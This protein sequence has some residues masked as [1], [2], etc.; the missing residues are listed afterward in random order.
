MA[1][2]V[3]RIFA[4]GAKDPT[5]EEKR[6]DDALW[7]PFFL[8]KEILTAF[9]CVYVAFVATVAILFGYSETHDGL[10]T[11]NPSYFLL[12]Q[13]GPTAVLTLVAAFWGQVE[14]RT[15]QLAPWALMA[16][17]PQPAER[18]ILLDFI[19]PLALVSLA[20][21][22]RTPGTYAVAVAIVG[23]LL[24]KLATVLSTGLF[25]LQP[26]IVHRAAHDLMAFN[27]F[28]DVNY[29]S[30]SI[31]R[32][33]FA[34]VSSINM[35]GLVNVFHSDLEC[36]TLSIERV[37]SWHYDRTMSSGEGT[38]LIFNLSSTTC[39]T[40]DARMPVVD[41]YFE[42]T[43]VY[44]GPTPNLDPLSASCQDEG[45]YLYVFGTA[46]VTETMEAVP[47]NLF[48]T[49]NLLC[50]PSYGVQQAQVTIHTNDST[51]Q[52]PAV[53]LMANSTPSM[54]PR[55]TPAQLLN[56]MDRS[57]GRNT[58]TFP[59][60]MKY[61]A[62]FI[63]FLVPNVSRDDAASNP[64]LMALGLKSL[65]QAVS[66]QI[67]KI[68]LMETTNQTIT[69][70]VTT[71]EERLVLRSL[72]FGLVAG[73]LVFLAILAAALVPIGPRRVVSCN[74]A[75]LGCLATILAHSPELE[76]TLRGTGILSVAKIRQ[77]LSGASYSTETRLSDGSAFG[78]TKSV[79]SA[80]EEEE[81]SRLDDKD[82]EDLQK[83][84]W[85][86]P[87]AVSLPA[88]TL[89]LIIPITVIIVLEVVYQQVQK[90][91]GLC[92]IP[93]NNY[94]HYAY[95]Y[96]PTFVLVCIGLMFVGLDFAAKI[97]QP[98]HI[99]RRGNAPSDTIFKQEYL[100]MVGIHCLWSSLR[101]G[102][103]AVASSSVG[104]IIA[105]LL[106]IAAS[107]LFFTEAIPQDLQVQLSQTSSFSSDFPSIRTT[108]SAADPYAN[109]QLYYSGGAGFDMANLV[110]I[111]GVDEPLFTYET[112]AFPALEIMSAKSTANSSDGLSQGTIAARIPAYRA[113]PNCTADIVT[114]ATYYMD[115]PSPR[116]DNIIDWYGAVNVQATAPE[117]CG[118]ANRTVQVL[119]NSQDA[120]VYIGYFSKVTVFED[121]NGNYG[122]DHGHNCPATLLVYGH[123]IDSRAVDL[124]AYYCTPYLERVTTNVTLN[125]ADLSFASPPVP[126]ETT[127]A[128][129]KNLTD[130]GAVSQG[131]YTPYSPASTA[132][133][134]CMSINNTSVDGFTAALLHLPAAPVDPASL[135]GP[136]NRAR[137]EAATD[138]LYGRIVAQMLNTA[139]TAPAEREAVDATWTAKA[140]AE[141]GVD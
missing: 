117:I 96:I 70:E 125:A 87:V 18:S 128:Y 77:R 19:E 118:I 89:M 106:T 101:R 130:I 21:S 97:F 3:K 100:G 123:V 111:D 80:A 16:N 26:T 73:I 93:S 114:N 116:S 40:I 91:N 99:L 135:S 32:R 28:K 133:G 132:G 129:V 58:Y 62:D 86:R 22:L 92:D 46:Q 83:P 82:Y 34:R 126:D 25:I 115:Y 24:L 78:I 60:G 41:G 98:Y 108:V 79:K 113:K 9:A 43:N 29:S 81:P 55:V 4:K 141:R 7:T 53:S 35:T 124:A 109:M 76:K 131:I 138:R 107:G 75:P 56:A 71:S 95:T 5:A 8:R 2:L 17:N 67:A 110:L 42:Y 51:S 120:D 136:P 63:T 14:Y 137:L 38:T 88:K 112:L 140:D 134:G 44:G 90:N 47:Y 36:E 121:S 104:M 57:Y 10:S 45:R 139:R 68:Y 37:S 64:D 27:D 61:Y 1:Q 13:Y 23:A 48:N 105:P 66:A 122:D 59:D 11:P 49:S 20:K 85:F 31:D 65:F 119:S 69:G 72:S 39:G 52:D 74:P 12:W 54:L 103:I 50:K 84:R 94:A 127:A 102:Q 15:K 30:L 33:A 6:D